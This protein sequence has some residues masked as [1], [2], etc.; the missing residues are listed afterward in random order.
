MGPELL[1]FKQFGCESDQPTEKSDCYALGMTILEVL[2][3][4]HPFHYYNDRTVTQRVCGGE[5][6]IIPTGPE[7]VW[8]TNDLW[9]MLGLCWLS[10]P[11]NRPA[12]E[13]VFENLEHGATTWEP[14]PPDLEGGAHPYDG[15]SRSTMTSLCMFLHFILSITLTIN[16]VL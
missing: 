10:E 15:D 11:N 13:V 2:S 12:L 8:F 14:L 1:D 9:E 3:G 5:R 16:Y 7:R 4:M 6:P